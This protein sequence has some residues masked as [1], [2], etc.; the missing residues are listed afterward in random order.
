MILFSIGSYFLYFLSK[1]RSAIWGEKRQENEA[2]RIKSAQQGLSGI[3]EV[4]LHGFEEIF[5]EFF[6]KSTSVSLNSA[7]KQTTLQ[8]MP[9]IFFELLTVIAISLLG[10]N[11]PIGTKF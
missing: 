6:S 2:K 7:M 1:N 9:K 10:N 4:K 8:G 3:K 5:A 11:S